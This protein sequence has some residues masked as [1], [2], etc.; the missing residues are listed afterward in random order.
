M[1]TGRKIRGQVG[2]TSE[3]ELWADSD[4]PRG[5]TDSEI[6]AAALTALD[7]SVAVPPGLVEVSARNGLVTLEGEVDRDYQRRV[8]VRAVRDL[9]GVRGVLDLV[10]VRAGR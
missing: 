4:A 3:W 6:A 7:L 1:D 2:E 8:A 5:E 10:R 9:P